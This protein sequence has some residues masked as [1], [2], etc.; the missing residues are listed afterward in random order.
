MLPQEFYEML[1]N[2]EILIDKLEEW[3][4][5]PKISD[6]RCTKCGRGVKLRKRVKNEKTLC[7]LRCTSC[8]SETSLFKNTFFKYQSENSKCTGRLDIKTLLKLI[9]AYFECK[10]TS[11]IMNI[12][13][14]KSRN[15]VVNWTNFI[16][17][18][19]SEFQD[20]R[21][22]IGGVNS[23]VE[24]D[25]TLMRGRRKNHQGR[26]LIGDYLGEEPDHNLR[27]SNYGNRVEGPWVFGMIKRGTRR[28]RMFY[29]EDRSRETLYPII[30]EHVNKDSKICSDQWAAY[31]TLGTFF[32]SHETVNHSEN[33]INPND[34][35]VHT[36]TVE[37]VWREAKVMLLVNL[38]GV[39][40]IH[41]Q[42]HLDFFSFVYEFK[43][44][45][46][47]IMFMQILG[48]TFEE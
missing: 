45:D 2:W 23:V 28:I 42:S 40:L 35:T 43:Y 39:P 14:I 18:R 38:R 5:L 33:F 22:K 41:L 3:G 34:S 15:T 46:P 48:N 27:R 7:Y 32:S 24:I 11:E 37:R 47:F 8:D 44:S 36:Q 21:E 17:E 9:Y 16:R 6:T 13:G 30:F 26:Y 20:T 31:A 25:E 29:V 10:K 19:I 4:V 12:T 1:G